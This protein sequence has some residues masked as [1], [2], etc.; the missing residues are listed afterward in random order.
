MKFE[1]ACGDVMPGCPATFSEET[2]DALLGEVA[3]HAAAAHG[4]TTIT[5]EVAEAVGAKVRRAG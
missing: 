5:P 3:A 1:L 2:E 4:I